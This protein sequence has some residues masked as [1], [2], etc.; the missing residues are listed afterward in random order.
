MSIPSCTF[1]AF[2]ILAVTSSLSQ[3]AFA[4]ANTQQTVSYIVE[5][6]PQVT[7]NM[8]TGLR[9]AQSHG[10]KVKY[11]YR[12]V[13]HGFAVQI[14]A[15]AEK[16]FVTA[17]SRNPL[18][19]NIEKDQVITSEV[20]TQT[21][22]TWGLD[23]IDQR[24]LPLNTTFNSDASGTG[25]NVY[26]VDTGILA[27]HNELSGRV[28]PG[29]SVVT[30]GYGTTDC[31]GH[32]THV[33]GTIAGVRYGVAKAASVIPVRVLDCNGSGS[34]SGVI[35]GIDWVVA[36]NPTRAIVN[37]SLGGVASTALDSAVTKAT[38]AGLVVV[39]AAGNNNANACNYSP[40]RVSSAIT[41][42]ATTSTDGRAS[43]SNY[44][45]CLDLF[46]PGSNITSA[47]Y[48]SA[49]TYAT[50]NGT[51][52]A[53]PHV[54]GFAAILRSL[55]PGESV[56]QISSRLLNLSTPN[57]ISSVGLGSPNRLLY[58]RLY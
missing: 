41:V 29:Y 7:D 21:N 37:M 33:A 35:A 22:A 36:Q 34:T 47:W 23:R 32:G 16:A 50:L 51:S 57:K 39:V 46:A 12:R 1:P 18:V 40:A 53:T 55:Y 49:S 43:Y 26:V 2:M 30:D 54:A 48:S 24:N 10:G 58:S 38:N 13:I 28:L 11:H 20:T 3:V 9:I 25:S 6:A 17:M 27:S 19:A 45:K 44:G 4:A 5:F 56:S 31:N 8:N 14:P 42:G 15:V 52:M